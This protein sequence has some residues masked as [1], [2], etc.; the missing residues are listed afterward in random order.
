MLQIRTNGALRLFSAALIAAAATLLLLSAS[1]ADA[2]D[3]ALPVYK[4]PAPPRINPWSLD[5]SIDGV[6]A[7]HNHSNATILENATTGAPLISGN[8]LPFDRKW[9]LDGRLRVGYEAW[10]VEARYFGGFK[11]RASNTTTTS[12]VSDFPTTPPLFV[13][14]ATQTDTRD[15]S[16]FDSWEANLRWR[17]YTNLV[18]FAGYRW[19]KLSDTLGM[20]LDFS[21]NNAVVSWD[22]SLRSRGPQIGAELRV[23]GPDAPFNPLGRVFLDLDARIGW[24]RTSGLQTFSVQQAVGSPF[25]A[26]GDFAK[27]SVAYELGAMLGVRVRPNVEVRAGYRYLRL[28]GAVRALDLVGATDGTID[29]TARSVAIHGA[30]VGVRILVP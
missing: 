4:A 21:T 13:L 25:A 8:Q 3:Q 22:S 19:M 18:V 27:T 20:S 7:R 17:A 26:A 9:G 29:P 2:A 12:G 16:R 15:D 30:T 28:G 10:S 24:L 23:F 14:G 6:F 1:G 11:W 5:A